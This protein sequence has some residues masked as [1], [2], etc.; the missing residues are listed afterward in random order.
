MNA[1]YYINKIVGIAFAA[2]LTAFVGYRAYLWRNDL[3]AETGRRLEQRIKQMSEDP[4]YQ[5]PTSEIEW[6]DVKFSVENLQGFN[7]GA[8]GVDSSKR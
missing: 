1:L 3:A 5:L 6:P 8:F 7:G 4:R 2:A